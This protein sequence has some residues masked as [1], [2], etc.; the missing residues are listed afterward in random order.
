MPEVSGIQKK[1]GYYIHGST[2]CTCC[3]NENFISGMYDSENYALDRLASHE[4]S[5]TVSSQYSNTG[6]Y[7]LYKTGYELLPDGRIILK[8]YVF[9]D[10]SFYE[11]GHIANDIEGLGESIISA[12][13]SDGG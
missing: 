11:S 12:G 1:T 10:D 9:D 13:K 7:T 2:G 8:N 6:L 4:K 5:R 3:R